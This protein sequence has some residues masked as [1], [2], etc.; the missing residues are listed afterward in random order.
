MNAGPARRRIPWLPIL[1]ALAALLAIAVTILRGAYVDGPLEPGAPTPQ[2]SK[3]IVSVL[4]DRGTQVSTARHTE[5]AAHALREGR[6]VLVTAP[7]TLNGAQLTALADARAAGG[8]RLILVSPNA[9]TLGYLDTGISVGGSERTDRTIP[10]GPACHDAAFRARQIAVHGQEGTFGAAISYRAAD[11]DSCFGADGTGLVAVEDGLIALGSGDLLSNET[12]GTADNSAV[13]LNALGAED[14]LL[15]YVP[16]ATDPMAS[17]STTLLSHLPGWVGPLAA[18]LFVIALLGLWAA[19]HRLGPVVVE[20]LP[21]RVR[22]Q[23]LVLGR[24][25]LLH[26]IG[27]RDAAASTLR[28]ATSARLADRLGLHRGTDLT[29]LIN[30][31]GE[32][33]DRSPEAL[34]TLLGPTPVPTDLDLVRLSHDLD[35]LEKEIES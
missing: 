12:I 16:S 19:S 7:S 21:V 25:R 10:A 33:V 5:D 26:R 9:V 13:A 3:A 34:R 1:T 23:E 31:V 18:W 4:G 24:A 28:S 14:T 11:G 6:P 22:A 17:S 8:G 35:R 20:P 32:H 2:G 27:A 30:A 29:V 15:W